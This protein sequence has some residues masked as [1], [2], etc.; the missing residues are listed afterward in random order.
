MKP[1]NPDEKGCTPISSNC[2]IWQ[3][4]NI[5]CIKLCKG[6]SI[7]DVTFKLATE[8]CKIM[9]ELDVSNYDLS[10]LNLTQC[11]PENFQQ[12]LQLIINKLC[13]A[14]GLSVGTGSAS[15]TSTQSSTTTGCPDCTVTIAECFQFNNPSN[16]DPVTSL[17]LSDYVQLIGLKV[18]TLV[19]QI[20]TQ[21]SQIT[22]LNNRVVILEKKP[23]PTFTLPS[24]LPVCVL[25]SAQTVITDVLVALEKQFCE[26]RSATGTVTEIYNAIAIQPSNLNT[27]KALGTQGGTMGEI[28]GWKLIVT[29]LSD[30]I[31]NIWLTLADLRSAVTNI[32]LNC[33]ATV[34]DG[35]AI[36]LNATLPSV[37]TLQLFFTGT[38]PA[39]LTE[40]D[41]ILGT[42]FTISDQSGNSINVR[43]K[44]I[45]NMNNPSGFPITLT[46][47]PIVASDDLTIT[48]NFCVQDAATGSTCQSCLE[49]VFINTLDCPAVNYTSGINTIEYSF[50]H[51]SGVKT[52]AIQLYNSAGTVLIESQTQSATNPTTISGTFSGLSANTTYK[53]RVVVI[54]TTKTISCPF[55]PITT[56]LDPCPAPTTVIAILSIP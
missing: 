35:V 55:T 32:K 39:G 48:S 23:T 51:T 11:D 28:S 44:V 1:T 37:N 33:C 3:G 25:P 47:T 19:L 30:S 24:I 46:G 29:D 49:F 14:L 38:I 42:L 34:C 27:A 21:T 10:C 50:S 7:S 54:T 43:V 56:L 17:L 13:E 40:C 41:E 12:L 8:L 26:L 18:C 15:R 36:V 45:D 53:A 16:G 4:P 5:E 20:N 6:D 22:N 2:V 9:E 52:Y 31:N